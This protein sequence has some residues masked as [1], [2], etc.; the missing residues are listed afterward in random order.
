MQSEMQ[1][2]WQLCS[3]DSLWQKLKALSLKLPILTSEY[4]NFDDPKST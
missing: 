3:I 1:S 2:E 4:V